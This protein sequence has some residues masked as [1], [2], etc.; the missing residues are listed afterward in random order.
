MRVDARTFACDWPDC[1]KSFLHTDNLASHRRQHVDPKPFRCA[2]CPLAYWQ[3]SSLRSHQAKQHH[4][5]PTAAAAHSDGQQLVDGIIR[6]VTASMRGAVAAADIPDTETIDQPTGPPSSTLD[7]THVD[8]P[9]S[10]TRAEVDGEEE[11]IADEQSTGEDHRRRG[12]VEVLGTAQDHPRSA[13]VEASLNV[14]EFCDDDAVNISRPSLRAASTDTQHG[15]VEQSRSTIETSHDATESPRASIEPAE[16]ESDEEGHDTAVF[17]D[18][19]DDV[20]AAV[21]RLAETT[22]TYSRSNR[23]LVHAPQPTSE[24][25]ADCSPVARLI[26]GGLF[27]DDDVSMTTSKKS[28]GTRRK[29]STSFTAKRRRRTTELAHGDNV[30]APAGKKMR[31]MKRNEPEVVEDGGRSESVS[32][33]SKLSARQRNCKRAGRK[34]ARSASAATSTS[35]DELKSGIRSEAGAETD[36]G[37][38]TRRSSSAARKGEKG[39]TGGRGGRR[40]RGKTDVAESEKDTSVVKTGVEVLR[41]GVGT[42]DS[43]AVS[44]VSDVTVSAVGGT[45]RRRRPRGRTDRV[46][47]RRS[48]R[49]RRKMEQQDEVE[50]DDELLGPSDTPAA[51][52]AGDVDELRGSESVGTQDDDGGTVGDVGRQWRGGDMDAGP[53][54]ADDEVA[55]QSDNTEIL[56]IDDSGAVVVAAVAAAGDDGVQETTGGGVD[57]RVSDVADGVDDEAS[58]RRSSPASYNS[59]D[60]HIISPA[61]AAACD[62][63]TSRGT[64]DSLAR[65]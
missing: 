21:D 40:G 9:R 30:D 23:K 53:E 62:D 6:S 45:R 13:A 19:D 5:P 39:N 52:A 37:Q 32:R 47:T 34:V 65:V 50:D 31:R 18:D 42:V 2:H 48:V 15:T 10:G 63:N 1:R 7:H 61:A 4:L 56:S 28:P 16:N 20:V 57:D 36:G 25:S 46:A 54:A 49:R 24:H 12:A 14:Y 33:T 35:A 58:T 59:D 11:V 22:I 44:V 3:K 60:E 17:D 26:A 55:Y 51:A 41:T 43:L 27:S 64:S 29:P 8:Q 38:V